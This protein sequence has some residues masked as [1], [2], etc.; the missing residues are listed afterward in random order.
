MY[1]FFSHI[2]RWHGKLYAR[3]ESTCGWPSRRSKYPKQR[4]ATLSG[5]DDWF[6]LCREL[7]WLILYCAAKKG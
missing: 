2:I 5:L 1:N 7:P 4:E 3:D 6:P